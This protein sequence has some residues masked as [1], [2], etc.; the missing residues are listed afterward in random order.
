MLI[1]N[2]LLLTC[3]LMI[4][5]Y[6][7][8]RLEAMKL[9]RLEAK[10]LMRLEARKLPEKVGD[11]RSIKLDTA[12]LELDYQLLEKWYKDGVS[13]ED[14]RKQSPAVDRIITEII[15][16]NK[17]DPIKPGMLKHYQMSLVL[18]KPVF[19][20]SDQVQHKQGC[21]VTED[22]WRLERGGGPYVPTHQ[23]SSSFACLIPSMYQL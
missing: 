16:R 11:V 14:A 4:V 6:D 8:R 18:R 12:K 7:A 9:A 19:G 17:Q 3:T 20:V 2:F 15:D 13:L 22:G 10:K 21:T 5:Q 23:F 1:T